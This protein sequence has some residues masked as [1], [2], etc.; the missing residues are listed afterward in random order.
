MFDAVEEMMTDKE[1]MIEIGEEVWLDRA[2]PEN[3]VLVAVGCSCQGMMVL[4]RRPRHHHHSSFAFAYFYYVLRSVSFYPF[5]FVVVVVAFVAVFGVDVVAA[6][7]YDVA[8]ECLVDCSF[9]NVSVG[10]N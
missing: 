7:A 3:F 8:E 4:E 5:V 10:S 9:A 2:L 6:V 1:T